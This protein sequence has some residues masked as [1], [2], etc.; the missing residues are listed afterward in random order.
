[1]H[2]DIGDIHSDNIMYKQGNFVFLDCDLWSFSNYDDE[3]YFQQEIIKG[4]NAAFIRDFYPGTNKTD[5]ELFV[6]GNPLLSKLVSDKDYN[7]KPSNFLEALITELER[8]YGK[9]ISTLK[10]MERALRL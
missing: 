2:L 4:F 8:Y 7:F 1:M 9:E 3:A 10:D 5:Y 6:W